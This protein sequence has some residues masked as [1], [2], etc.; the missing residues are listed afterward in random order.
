MF[1]G[2]KQRLLL[3]L[4]VFLILSIPV[5]AYL[6]SKQQNISSQASD[7]TQAEPG[8][9]PAPKAATA[10]AKLQLLTDSLEKSKDLAPS[11]TPIPSDTS[12]PT[13]ASSFGPTLSFSV[14]LEGRPEGQEDG[15]LFVGIIEGSLSTNPKFILSFKV[16][17]PASGLYGNLSL[18]GL[19]VGSKYTALLKGPAQIATSSAFVVSPDVTKLEGGEAI[20]LTSGD[21]NEDNV[22]NSSDYSIVL[23]AYG[24]TPASSN[25]NA[26]A[27]FNKDGVINAFDL[28]IVSKNLGQTGSS[29]AWTSPIP[30]PATSSASLNNNPPVGGPAT[31]GNGYWMWVPK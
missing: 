5:G 19:T 10:S 3:G 28:S 13:I 25:W 9:N 16:D 15:K 7:S 12:S 21:L 4:Y 22:V 30:T 29:G 8:T 1:S 31:S 27:D 20:N 18:A 6:A 26:G 2:L 24:A 14:K 11:P 23:K 17:V